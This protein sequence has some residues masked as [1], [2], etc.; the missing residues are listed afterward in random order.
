MDKNYITLENLEV[1]QLSRRL[2]TAAWTIYASMDIQT[3]LI[4]GDQFIRSI[5]SVG[6]NIAE[7]YRR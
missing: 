2:C 1:Y 7:G 3:K 4:M 6:A 5:D